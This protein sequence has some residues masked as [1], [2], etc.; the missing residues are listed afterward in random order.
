MLCCCNTMPCF[1][2]VNG[3]ALLECSFPVIFLCNKLDT[4]KARNILKLTLDGQSSLN[5]LSDSCITKINTE[6]TTHTALNT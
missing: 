4:C 5:A 6:N 3:P 1:S 2:R